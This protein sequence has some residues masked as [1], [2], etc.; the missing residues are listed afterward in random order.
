MRYSVLP[1]LA[2][3]VM[4]C[5]EKD[6]VDSEPA[7]GITVESTIPA[8]GSTTAYYRGAVEFYLSDA[9]ASAELSI[10]GVAGTSA[11]NEDQDVVT[12]TPSAPLAPNTSYTATLT[13][14][15]GETEVTF[16]TSS[17]GGDIGD[18]SSLNGKVF[19]LDLKSGRIVIPEG[20]GSVLENYLDVVIYMEVAEA[21]GSEIQLFGAL[22]D[23]E[24]PGQQDY[25]SQTLDFPAAD[26]SEAPYFKIGPATTTIAVAG[27]EVTIDDLEISG[28]FAAD[29]SYWGG[30]T[31]AGSVD[32]RALVDLIEEGGDENT[33]CELVAGFGVACETCTGDGQPFCLSIKAV[34]LGGDE[35][36]GSDLEEIAMS[37]CHEQC[38]DSASNPECML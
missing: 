13:Y 12:F 22:A 28:T 14:C 17:L 25:C 8:S 26:F 6:P 7:C 31:L 20:V 4:A 30:G 35:A 36:S 5:G 1:I 27:Y 19:N 32:T 24:N 38:P 3:S 16:T 23:E 2:F 21:N 33:V 11:L 37:D 15:S 9:D 29:G 10:D 18:P 34:D